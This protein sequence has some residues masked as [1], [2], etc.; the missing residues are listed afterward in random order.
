MRSIRQATE[1][2]YVTGY[3]NLDLATRCMLARRSNMQ[4]GCSVDDLKARQAAFDA[5]R[6][7]AR[8]R[9]TWDDTPERNGQEAAASLLGRVAHRTGPLK[10]RCQPAP[11]DKTLMEL[12]GHVIDTNEYQAPIHHYDV[13]LPSHSKRRAAY[14]ALLRKIIQS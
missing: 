14:L 13:W 10:T 8:G 9:I 5:A 11:H 3:D 7:A 6:P 4:P 12:Q 1:S 2:D